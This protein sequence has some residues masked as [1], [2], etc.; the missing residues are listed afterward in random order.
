MGRIITLNDGMYNYEL[1]PVPYE[2]DIW[3]HDVPKK[4]QYWKTP[5][6]KNNKWLN[7][8]G[9][10]WNVSKMKERDR[11]EYINYWRDK[12]ENGLWI[13]VKGEPTYM[14]GGHVEH[15][16]F[17]MFKNGFFECQE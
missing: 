12:W 13:M 16:V 1:P 4:M 15:L 2:K 14:T 8:D 9:R 5:A 11:I 7:P 10:I 6:N 3:Y 17:N